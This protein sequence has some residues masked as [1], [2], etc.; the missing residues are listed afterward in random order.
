MQ[1]FF[2]ILCLLLFNSCTTAYGEERG[3]FWSNVDRFL[4]EIADGVSKTDAIT[5]LRTFDSPFHNEEDY[6]RQGA[7][8]LK[9]I[10]QMAK[11]LV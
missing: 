6:H 8:T 7:E 4:D 11:M 9:L 10:K 5:G 2:I 1:N 3:T